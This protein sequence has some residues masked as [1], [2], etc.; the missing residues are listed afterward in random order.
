MIILEEQIQD[1]R[2]CKKR[3]KKIF[4]RPCNFSPFFW[5]L[6]LS[7]NF[8]TRLDY[9]RNR[10]VI[11]IILVG[12]RENLSEKKLLAF[13]FSPL[14]ILRP[15]FISPL[16]LHHLP[17]HHPQTL[18][19]PLLLHISPRSLLHP[20]LWHPRHNPKTLDRER[21]FREVVLTPAKRL[22]FLTSDIVSLCVC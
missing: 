18:R 19:S 9:V 3:K 8:K 22:L 21:Y 16:F 11:I 14:F 6:R 5:F 12:E 7:L 4:I 15:F 10:S 2:K 20:A 1:A 13:R 17:F